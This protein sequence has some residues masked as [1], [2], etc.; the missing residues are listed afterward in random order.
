MAAGAETDLEARFFTAAAELLAGYSAGA[1]PLREVVAAGNDEIGRVLAGIAENGTLV[2]AAPVDYLIWQ[3]GMEGG[4]PLS[5]YAK[6]ELWVTGRVSPR[7][8]KELVA[9]GWTV[10]EEVSFGS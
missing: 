9:R 6:R 1:G 2:V 10:K 8:K 3:A 5:A 4:G 7:A